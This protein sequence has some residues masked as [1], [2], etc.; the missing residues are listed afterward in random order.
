MKTILT[1]CALGSLIGCTTTVTMPINDLNNYHV[2]CNDRYN[3]LAFLHSQIPT[4]NDRLTNA[5][6]MT[7]PLGLVHSAYDGTY[8]DQRAVY[9]RKQSAY[10]LYWIRMIEQSCPV[11]TPKPQSCTIIREQFPAGDSQGVLCYTRQ[12]LKPIVN[13]WEP[14]VDKR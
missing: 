8:Q 14:L 13:R 11:D 5:L 7:S 2:N 4:R 3:Q 10:A 6:Q 9:D 1:I 12:D